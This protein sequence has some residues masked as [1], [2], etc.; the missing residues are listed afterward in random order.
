MWVKYDSSETFNWEETLS[1]SEELTYARYNDWRLPN[2][3]E[4]Q[5]LVDYNRAPDTLNPET[6]ESAIDTIF[7]ITET[8][9]WFW[10]STTHL[11]GLGPSAAVY[12]VF[13]RATGYM[14]SLTGEKIYM[15]DHGAGV[16]RSDPKS[17]DP[18]DYAGGLSP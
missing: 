4:L 17:E 18:E 16:Q 1:Y 10:S 3:R 5:S 2:A 15:N 12:L 14:S 6:I 11:E 7:N 9:S 13:G 8:K